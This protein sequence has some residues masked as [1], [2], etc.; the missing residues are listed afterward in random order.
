MNPCQQRNNGRFTATHGMKDSRTYGLWEAMLTRVKSRPAYV[1]RNITVCKD[2]LKFEK[3][4]ADMGDAPVGKSLDRID[5]DGNYEPSNCRWATHT[6][7]MNNRSNNVVIEWN[8]KS[9][10]RSQWERELNMKPTTLRSRLKA[11]WSLD[12]AMQPLPAEEQA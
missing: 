9:Q 4:Y 2:W 10:T 6:Q 1:E 7:Q 3:F 5:N 12:R 8:G 11:G